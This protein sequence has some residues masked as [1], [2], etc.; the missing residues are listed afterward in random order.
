GPIVQIGAAI[1]SGVGSV[2]RLARTQ[3]PV[4]VGCGAA[5]GISAIFNA[6]MGGL[7]FALE[8]LLQDFSLRNVTPIVVASVIANVATKAIFATVFHEHWNAI[9]N[10][11]PV[12]YELRW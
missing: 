12:Y 2:F 10:I 1:A 4:V 7:L 8:V 11:P 3:M 6:P 9:F 5:A